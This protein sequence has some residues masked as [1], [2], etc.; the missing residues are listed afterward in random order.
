MR[1]H[2]SR[3]TTSTARW[4][5]WKR[6]ARTSCN[7]SCSPRRRRSTGKLPRCRFRKTRRWGFRSAPMASPSGRPNCSVSRT[8]NCTACRWSVCGR[9]ASMV[10]GSG[11]TWR[12]AIFAEAILR[13]RPIPL[14]G[15]GSQRRDFTHVCDVCDGL[16]AALTAD[17]VVG[18]AIN[19]G[20][21]EPVAVR[22]LIALLESAARPPG[23][24]RNAAG[25]PGRHARDLRGPGKARRLLGYAPKLRWPT[26]CAT[27]P[28]GL[29]KS[30]HNS[31]THWRDADDTGNVLAELGL[32]PISSAT[33]GSIASAQMFVA[34]GAQV[35][36]V[37]HDLLGQRAVGGEK[38]V[39]DVEIEHVLVVGQL[40]GDFAGLGVLF[41]LR[42]SALRRGGRRPGSAPWSPAAFRAAS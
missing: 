20:H 26:A 30:R 6:R 28:P 15:D 3:Q 17:D 37:G 40:R 12:C 9:S 29:C 11:R 13:G 1:R 21:D 33:F 25:Q 27:S 42:M 39:A 38:L 24:R 8:C 19:L 18:E 16:L 22:D 34:L 32:V 23:A 5:C 36:E 4:R 10:R 14:F 31:A 2:C 7:A 35:Q 41:A